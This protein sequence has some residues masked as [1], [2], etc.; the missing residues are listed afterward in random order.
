[1]A[2]PAR[3]WCLGSHPVT[4]FMGHKMMA[5]HF[6]DGRV[7]NAGRLLSGAGVGFSIS[8][9]AVVQNVLNDRSKGI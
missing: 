9:C 4:V 5:G 3:I 8:A 1:M 7:L 2:T 6:S